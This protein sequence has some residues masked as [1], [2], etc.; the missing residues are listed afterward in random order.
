MAC[1]LMMSA[2]A[3]S[4]MQQ[5]AVKA[6][7]VAESRQPGGA[8]MP[9]HL[10]S[11]PCSLAFVY[12]T[13]KH[14]FSNHWLIEDVVGSGHAHFLGVAKTKQRFPLVCGPFQVP[15]LL[16]M[17]NSGLQVE[18]ELYAVDQSALERLDELEGVS[19]GHYQRCPLVLTGL[20]SLE[21]DCSP[22]SEILGD[23]SEILGRLTSRIRHCNRGCQVR[24]ISTRTR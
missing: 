14:G 10:A 9:M 2:A 6:P 3:S 22:S 23:A 8:M 5:Q 1:R 24:R 13:L 17:P 21:E 12:G 16:N 20:T 19:K 11:P 18:G 4:S 15:F 7:S